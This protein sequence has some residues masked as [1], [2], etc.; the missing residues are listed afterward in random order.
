[1][2]KQGRLRDT[3]DEMEKIEHDL[4]DLSPE[5]KMIRALVID[6]INRYDDFVDHLESWYNALDAKRK[7]QELPP[8]PRRI[9]TLEDAGQLLEAITRMVERMHKITREGSISLDVFRG[10]MGQMGVIVAREVA[11]SKTLDRIEQGWAEIMVNPKSFIRGSDAMPHL[12]N[13]AID[14]EVIRSP[15]QIAS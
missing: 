4:M 7:D 1:M 12:D 8:V 13:D 9:P 15:K 6:F 2:I 11:D 5:I 3:L 14:V 10:L